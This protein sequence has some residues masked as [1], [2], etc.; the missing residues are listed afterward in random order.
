MT[1]SGDVELRPCSK[2]S[3]HHLQCS[4]PAQVQRSSHS[5]FGLQS[6]W[7][8]HRTVIRTMD[9]PSTSTSTYSSGL[10][11][12]TPNSDYEASKVVKLQVLGV[13]NTMST[14]ELENIFSQCGD[15][16]INL[17]KSSK[18]V[19]IEYKSLSEAKS[20]IERFDSQE[21]YNFKLVIIRTD[22]Q[23]RPVNPLSY[24]PATAYGEAENNYYYRYSK[25]RRKKSS[26]CEPDSMQPKI[27]VKK[28][29]E[30]GMV[31]KVFIASLNES[32]SDYWVTLEEDTSTLTKLYYEFNMRI[33]DRSPGL[34]NPAVDDWCC[35][36]FNEVWCRAR[37]ISLQPLELFYVDYGYVD[38]EVTLDELKMLPA[39]MA[40][41]PPLAIHVYHA[42]GYPGIS[43]DHFLL[44]FL[45]EDNGK[46]TVEDTY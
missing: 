41:R 14:L 24:M 31:R 34:K 1:P 18:D 4:A 9:V 46:W 37:I 27:K 39:D 40:V 22:S 44:R 20:A 15:P 8:Y 25:S 23:I 32:K 10:E 7:N 17:N 30:P 2:M 3:H 21:P 33:T 6:G 11:A 12:R 16:T 28:L 36:R 19:F 26:I 29:I 5:I 43:T 42:A 35:R 45:S 38:S 13:P